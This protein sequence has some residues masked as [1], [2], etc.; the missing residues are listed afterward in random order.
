[1]CVTFLIINNMVLS[2]L[3]GFDMQ[4]Y[5]IVQNERATPQLHN[6]ET[7]PKCHP[8]AIDDEGNEKD[9]SFQ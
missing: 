1:M 7:G 2:Q 4:S 9:I 5:T 8:M 3:D 6:K